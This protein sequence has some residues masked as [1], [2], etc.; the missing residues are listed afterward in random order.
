MKIT[1]L[2]LCFL[3]S[4]LCFSTNTKTFYLKKPFHQAENTV[5]KKILIYYKD[6]TLFIKGL[7]GN[8]NLKIY[9]IIGNIISDINLQDLSEVSLPIELVRQNMYIIRVETFE[10][11]IFTHKIVAR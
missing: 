10:N 4:S 9:S 8:G 1:I 6:N 7:N 3:V 11:T 5:Q 2:L